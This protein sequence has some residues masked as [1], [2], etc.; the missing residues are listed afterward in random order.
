[1]SE[2]DWVDSKETPPVREKDEL[3]LAAYRRSSGRG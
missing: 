1:M 3:H 2:A